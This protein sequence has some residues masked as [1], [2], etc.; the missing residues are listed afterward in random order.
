MDT[1]I[2]HAFVSLPFPQNLFSSIL[3]KK[4]GVREASQTTAHSV[5]HLHATTWCEF[6]MKQQQ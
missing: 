6:L 2:F 4:E 5:K 1:H 3:T